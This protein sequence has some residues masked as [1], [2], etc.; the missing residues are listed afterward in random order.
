MAAIR[1]EGSAMKYK[2]H[3]SR[4]CAKRL[5]ERGFSPIWISSVLRQREFVSGLYQPVKWKLPG[6]N[7]VIVYSDFDHG[8]YR[9]R[10]VVTAYREG[11]GL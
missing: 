10:T 11:E 3:I 2:L 9:Q 1:A 7:E 6:S 8:G 5:R 4:H